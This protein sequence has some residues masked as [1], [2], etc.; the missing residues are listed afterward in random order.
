VDDL[1]GRIETER[2]GV[3][4]VQVMDFVALAFKL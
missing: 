1:V 2:G 4:D 3:A